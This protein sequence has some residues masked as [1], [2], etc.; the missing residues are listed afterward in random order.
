MAASTEPSLAQ[1]DRYLAADPANQ[2]LLVRAFETAL[3]GGEL[4][5]ANRYLSAGEAGGTEAL[6]WALRRAHLFMAGRNWQA[7]RETLSQ[8]RLTPEAPSELLAAIDQDLALIDLHLGEPELAADRLMPWIDSGAR[9]TSTLQALWL[10]AM[11]RA[12]RLDEGMRALARWQGAGWLEPEA[13]GVGALLALDADDLP[14]SDQLSQLALAKLPR[15]TEAL[16]ASGSVAL[17]R[18]DANSARAALI[19]AL[20]NQPADGRTL[21][22][23]AFA[24]MLAGELHEARKRFE[25]ALVAM[26]P[27][28][29]TWQGLGWCC[30]LLGDLDGADTAFEESL[31][32]DRNFAEGHGGKAVVQARRGQSQAARH[33]IAV[34]LKLDQN[35]MSARY[36]EAVLN[37]QDRDLDHLNALASQ[38]LT[39]TR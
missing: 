8:L 1:L 25:Q 27:H 29:G 33:S 6:A 30:L 4:D 5:A 10:R 11:H 23:L 37:G 7:A 35:C 15:Q 21:S 26:P 16:I 14:R 17:G 3:H 24:D 22:T 34:A 31:G 13:A 12:A 39:R 18:R 20:T 19:G 9:P 36:A 2:G 38:L 32:R 28:L